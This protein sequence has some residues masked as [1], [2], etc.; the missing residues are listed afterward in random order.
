[1]VKYFCD[2]CNRELDA[3]ATLEAAQ[4]AKAFNRSELFCENQ[5]QQWAD[6]YW[7]ACVIVEQKAQSVYDSTVKNFRNQFF[8]GKTFMRKAG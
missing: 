7:G 8:S 3:Q 6:E 5:C 2:G 4:R 1:M